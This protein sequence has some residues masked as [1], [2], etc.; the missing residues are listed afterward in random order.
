MRASGDEVE[1]RPIEPGDKGSLIDALEQSSGEAIYSRFLNPHGRLTASELRY[2]TEVDHS[3][4]EALMAFDRTSGRGVGVARYIRDQERPERAEIAVSVLETWQGR[5]VG[6]ALL[7][8]LARRAGEEGITCFVA[9]MLAENRPMHRLFAQLGRPR[10]L[11]T[12]AGAVELA[13][14]LRA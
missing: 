13:V 12:G 3:D 7:H 1:I 4:H 8:D 10:V 9:L 14:D 2:L 5:G 6:R 11:S